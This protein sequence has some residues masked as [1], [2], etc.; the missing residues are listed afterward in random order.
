[1]VDTSAAPDP[2]AAETPPAEQDTAPQEGAEA[3][4]EMSA[5]WADMLE[6][7]GEVEPKEDQPEET[8]ETKEDPP[9][10]AAT[11]AEGE[12]TAETETAD[13]PSE[14]EE[15]AEID[16]SNAPEELRSAFEAEKARADAAVQGRKSAEGRYAASQRRLDALIAGTGDK[17]DDKPANRSQETETDKPAE[18][19]PSDEWK[20]VMADYPEIAKPLADEL[21]RISAGYRAEIDGL[22]QTQAQ[23]ATALQTV[24]EDRLAESSATQE[25]IVREAHTD[26]DEIADSDEFVAWANEQP[27]FIRQGIHA[28]AEMIVD[29]QGVSRILDMYK[30]DKGIAN[31]KGNGA[32][33]G[34]PPGDEKPAADPVRQIQLASSRGT[35]APSPGVQ[36]REDTDGRPE[37]EE[38]V[39]AEVRAAEQRKQA[40]EARA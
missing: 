26:Y 28:N 9:E 13:K 3:P 14:A 1:M 19:E 30:A 39:W 33:A 12:E 34:E 8:E 31:G 22:K 5:A 7:T 15:P 11:A 21:A 20:Q 35:P 24:G 38:S 29:G 23:M 10:A 40:A 36:A 6:E 32:A 25:S 18:T 27:E 2:E 4:D 16:W 17:P 37:T